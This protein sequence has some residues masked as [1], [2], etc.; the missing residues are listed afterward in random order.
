MTDVHV[1][2]MGMS[3]VEVDIR[4]VLVE[5]GERVQAGEAL[6]EIEGDKATFE[7]EAPVAG[8]VAEVLVEDGDERKVGDVV[9]RIRE[10]G[11]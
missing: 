7:V 3:T 2:K 5:V 11:A 8:I 10:E 4:E 6:L 9:V 1:P